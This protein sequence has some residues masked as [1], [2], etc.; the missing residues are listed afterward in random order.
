M[1][2]WFELEV[3]APYGMV[4]YAANA[5]LRLGVLPNWL[6]GNGQAVQVQPIKS[7][8]KAPGTKCLKLICDNLLSKF[9]CNF[10]LRRFATATPTSCSGTTRQGLPLV[11]STQI[12][13]GGQTGMARSAVRSRFL[14]LRHTKITLTNT[15]NL[16][17]ASL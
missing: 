7:T 2:F 1:K 16:S 15:E 4:Y 12:G 6:F 14:S 8:L 3:A 11:H 17:V 10:N 5:T 9:A 13:W